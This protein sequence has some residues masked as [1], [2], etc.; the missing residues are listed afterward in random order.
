MKELKDH[1]HILLNMHPSLRGTVA[2]EKVT[3]TINEAIA[4]LGA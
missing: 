3:A 4:Q 2:E 1:V